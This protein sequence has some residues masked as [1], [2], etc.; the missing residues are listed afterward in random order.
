[1]STQPSQPTSNAD[2]RPSNSMGNRPSLNEVYAQQSREEAETQISALK[3]AA[4]ELRKR[5]I[6]PKTRKP[7][8]PNQK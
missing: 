4:D 8:D 5:G 3:Q 7:L 2:H 6:D 1:M